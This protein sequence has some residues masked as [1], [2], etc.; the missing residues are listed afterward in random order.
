MN[1]LSFGVKFDL[2]GVCL[3]LPL[4]SHQLLSGVRSLSPIRHPDRTCER[5]WLWVLDFQIRR[6]LRGSLNVCLESECGH[7]PVKL[8]TD[9][10][11]HRG[12]SK[13]G[14]GRLGHNRS[15]EDWCGEQ[16]EFEARTT[17]C[18]TF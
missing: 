13:G 9:L 17:G 7:R 6:G 10:G 8:K 3:F 11:A 1:R 15:G 14:C 2:I 5:R 4:L 18:S 16:P 12:T